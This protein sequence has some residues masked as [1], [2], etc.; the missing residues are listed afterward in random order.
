M[1]PEQHVWACALEVERQHGERASAF[2]AERIASLTDE[3]DAAGVAMWQAIGG[4][5]DQL[6]GR[7]RN[8]GRRPDRT[9]GADYHRMVRA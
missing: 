4:R 8:G 5:L 9:G 2:V 6:S 7:D 1:T 3:H